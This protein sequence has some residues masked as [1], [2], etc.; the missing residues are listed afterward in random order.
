VPGGAHVEARER[1][2]FGLGRSVEVPRVGCANLGRT[3][4]PF[5]CVCRAYDHGCVYVHGSAHVR[6]EVRVRESGRT[7]PKRRE[8]SPSEGVDSTSSA[9]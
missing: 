5:G 9:G 6:Q 7:H 2:S 3:A 4:L 8:G 1:W